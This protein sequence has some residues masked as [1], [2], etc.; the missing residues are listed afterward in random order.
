[1]DM[2]LEDVQ[3]R[4]F[5]RRIDSRVLN[6]F[7]EGIVIFVADGCLQRDGFRRDFECLVDFAHGHFH[8]F[9]DLRHRRLTAEFL[10]KGA[11]DAPNLVNPFMHVNGDADGAPLVG[12]SSRDALADPP[13][14]ISAELIAALVIEFI[15]GAHQ[16][17]V[18][19]LN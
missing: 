2:L 1:M 5:H 16:T 17:D 12:D 18:A 10:D 14:G 15:N 8:V 7:A 9:G 11:L 13:R 4:L 19:F 6:E 3:F